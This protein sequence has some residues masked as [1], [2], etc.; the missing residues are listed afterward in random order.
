M[1]GIKPMM[2]ITTSAA[3]MITRSHFELPKIIFMFSS[4]LDN[5]A[6]WSGG[7]SFSD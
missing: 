3:A 6:L 2:M 4:E 1:T 5:H 7:I